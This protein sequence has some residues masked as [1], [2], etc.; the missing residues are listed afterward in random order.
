MSPL[1]A[2]SG[3]SGLAVDARAMCPVLQSWRRCPHDPMYQRAQFAVK[4][5]RQPDDLG[6]SDRA[7]KLGFDADLVGKGV[8]TWIKCWTV[9][10]TSTVPSPSTW[11]PPP[12]LTQQARYDSRHCGRQSSERSRP[13]GCFPFRPDVI[14]PAIEDPVNS[15]QHGGACVIQHEGGAEVAHPEFI[16]RAHLD[17]TRYGCRASPSGALPLEGSTTMVTVLEHGDAVRDSAVHAA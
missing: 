7:R 17:Q 5:S 14:A 15:T 13:T 3:W 9:S 12:S 8:A 2:W 11:M 10:V 1:T 16:H 6:G 4:T